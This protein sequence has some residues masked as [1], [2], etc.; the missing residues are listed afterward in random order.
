MA[1]IEVVRALNAA[2]VRAVVV[3]LA[4][5]VLFNSIKDRRSTVIV[6]NA[7]DFLFIRALLSNIVPPFIIAAL[8][9]FMQKKDRI[10]TITSSYPADSN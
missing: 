6:A 4:V 1:T 2:A 7:T 3:L 10:R 9:R 8:V 5:Q